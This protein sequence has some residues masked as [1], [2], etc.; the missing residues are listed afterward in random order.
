[1]D[2]TL[3]RHGINELYDAY[4]ELRDRF[5]CMNESERSVSL[6][7][8]QFEL[9]ML[10]KLI[11]VDPEN[12]D[13][14]CD[15]YEEMCWLSEWYKS[16][17]DHIATLLP[18]VKQLRGYRELRRIDAERTGCYM[19]VLNWEESLR[20]KGIPKYIK[21][22][23]TWYVV[24]PKFFYTSTNGIYCSNKSI[25]PANDIVEQECVIENCFA[26]PKN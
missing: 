17:A 13:S 3:G 12:I 5:E 22:G 18:I 14:F 7:D 21:I 15:F 23:G 26:Y 20:S 4:L 16:V 8:W 6:E 19:P 1:M 10:K 11:R 9:D 24:D 2:I 25:G